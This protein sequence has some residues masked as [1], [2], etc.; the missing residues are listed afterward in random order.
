MNKQKIL[1]LADFIESIPD[2]RFNMNHFSSVYDPVDEDDPINTNDFR[3]F[4]HLDYNECNTAGCIAGWTLALENNGR[5]DIGFVSNPYM[6]DSI[7]IRAG[8]YLGLSYDETE[9]LFFPNNQGSIW[10]RYLCRYYNLLDEDSKYHIHRKYDGANTENYLE[11]YSF[12]ANDSFDLTNIRISNFCAAY[13]LRMIAND[14]FVFM[15]FTHFKVN[16]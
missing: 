7:A 10:K 3:S 9:Q 14:Q 16:N 1:E 2:S 13:V 4:V 11:Q 8:H 12:F 6:A 15:N 5:V